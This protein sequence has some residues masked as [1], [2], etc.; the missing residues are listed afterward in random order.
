MTDES[1]IINGSYKDVPLRISEA[2]VTGGR[3][4]AIKQFPSRDTQSVE[5]LGKI[6]RRH[7]LQIIISDRQNEDYFAYR[8]RL[9]RV[10]ESKGPG[11]LEHPL[12]GRIENVVVATFSLV[13]NYNSFGDATI[14]VN[15]E[16]TENT[17]I[18]KSSDNVISQIVTAN[19]VVQDGVD[20]N[21][22]KF[23]QVNNKFTGNFTAAVSKVTAIVDAVEGVVAFT[24]EVADTLNEFNSE[25]SQLRT[26]IQSLVSNPKKLASSITNLFSGVDGLFSAPQTTFDSFL[27]IFGFG[28][29]DTET[30]TST[31]GLAERKRND[32][33]LNSAVNAAILGY[34]YLASTEIQFKTTREIDD[35]VNSLDAQYDLVQTGTLDQTTKDDVTD[36]R[37]K[38]LS[39]YDQLRLDA[40]FIITVNTVPTTVRIL[41]FDYYGSDGLGQAIA[42]LNQF[43]N[44]SFIEGD[45][46]ILTP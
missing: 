25:I 1:K 11:L 6:P 19:Q 9:L 10:L 35:L 36:M 5:D 37:V 15:F 38:S 30:Q 20:A 31:A 46:E 26:D 13:E 45:V 24:G 34:A 40:N 21:I 16:T 22:A 43:D 32:D 7:S 33:I 17:G 4:V 12:F 3:K 28:I 23:F 29:G 27:G 18:P 8:D 44:V 14:S 41:T 2:S 39:V 42:D